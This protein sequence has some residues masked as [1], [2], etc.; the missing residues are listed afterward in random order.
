MK[1]REASTLIIFITWII[2]AMFIASAKECREERES[3]E[4]CCD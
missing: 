3:M 2:G 1:L 4:R